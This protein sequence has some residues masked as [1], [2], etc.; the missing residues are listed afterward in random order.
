M[1]RTQAKTFALH[2][3]ENPVARL[4]ASVATALSR[5]RD[6]AMLA[7]LDA[8]LLRDIGLDDDS[9]AKE[10]AKPFWQP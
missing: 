10:S 5:R 2:R 9:A 1:P 8:H 7:R 6:R 4:L 3:I